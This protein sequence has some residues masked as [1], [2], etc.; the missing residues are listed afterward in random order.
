MATNTKYFELR[1]GSKVCYRNR[2]LCNVKKYAAQSRY[3]RSTGYEIVGVEDGGFY[4]KFGFTREQW[5]LIRDQIRN[6]QFIN[7]GFAAIFDK[8]QSEEDEFVW[9]G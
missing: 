2:A 4:E 7:Y 3:F 1:Q 6:S 9:Q 5:D 8:E